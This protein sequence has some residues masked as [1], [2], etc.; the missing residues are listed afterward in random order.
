MESKQAYIHWT[1]PAHQYKKLPIGILYCPHIVRIDD[2][3]QEHWSVCF[4]ITEVNRENGGI[5]NLTMLIENDTT[6]AFFDTLT[7]NTSFILY[8]AHTEVARG[9]IL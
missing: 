6:R 5:I 9:Y 1:H 7:S 2:P 8:E 4:D 3:N